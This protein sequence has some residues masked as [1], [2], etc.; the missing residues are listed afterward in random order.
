M[1][2]RGAVR[3]DL[4]HE[5]DP[6]AAGQASH[7]RGWDSGCHA[8]LAVQAAD[9]RRRRWFSAPQVPACAVRGRCRAGA[10]GRRSRMVSMPGLNDRLTDADYGLGWSVVCRLPASWTQRAFGFF[11][12][13]AWR[14]QGPG[15]RVLEGNLRRVIG[16]EA[17]GG[18]LRA[19]SRE[20]M[21]SYA[22]YWLEAF[23]LPVMPAGPAGGGAPGR[24]RRRA[25]ARAP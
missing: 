8:S 21:R 24:R 10:A 13:L 23:R 16:S 12:D 20:A 5:R 11:A 25:G 1:P 18:Q 22:R 19:L 6:P 3:A 7:G 9:D 15:A 4:P 14:R 17:A 2:G